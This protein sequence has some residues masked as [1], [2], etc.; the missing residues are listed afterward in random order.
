MGGLNGRA[1]HLFSFRSLPKP[2]RSP[3]QG[4][5]F[6]L[7]WVFDGVAAH[8]WLPLPNTILHSRKTLMSTLIH[9]LSEKG[10]SVSPGPSVATHTCTQSPA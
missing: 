7:F 1:P 10:L 4:A 3:G 6:R 5:V 9:Y 2:D 8:G